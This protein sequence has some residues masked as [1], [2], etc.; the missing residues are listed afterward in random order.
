MTEKQIENFR[1]VLSM[2]IGPYALIMPEADVIAIR[3]KMQTDIDDNEDLDDVEFEN[4]VDEHNT[5][6]DTPPLTIPHPCPD[7]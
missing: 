1:K 7:E 3:D 4:M 6:D 2:S 5:D